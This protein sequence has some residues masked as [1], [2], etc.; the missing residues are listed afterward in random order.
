[1]DEGALTAAVIAAVRHQRTDYD[2]MLA[3]GMDRLLARQEIADKVE[4]I[5][6]GWR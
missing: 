4:A 1:L 6:A 5:L 3:A 2:A